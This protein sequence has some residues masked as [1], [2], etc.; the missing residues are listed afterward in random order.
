MTNCTT[1]PQSSGAVEGERVI[2]NFDEQIKNWEVSQKTDKNYLGLMW[3]HPD[4]GFSDSLTLSVYFEAGDDI[5][6]FRKSQDEPGVSQCDLFTSKTVKEDYVNN[7]PSQLWGADCKRDGKTS[8][9]VIHLVVKS[10]HVLYH[11]R[12]LWKVDV[13]KATYNEWLEGFYTVVVCDPRSLRH[14]CPG[15]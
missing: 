6:S 3:A 5:A 7:Y 1:V 13:D 9:K 14:A 2:L 10:D 12:K 11:I 8:V 4:K 15:T